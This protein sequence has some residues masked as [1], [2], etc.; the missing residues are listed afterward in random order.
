MPTFSEQFIKD[1]ASPCPFCGG[2]DLG[3]TYHT[4]YGHGESGYEGLRVI[5]KC[6]ASKGRGFGYGSPGEKEIVEVVEQWNER[7]I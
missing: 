1:N 6:G 5:C 2:T 4:T 3:I 7:S